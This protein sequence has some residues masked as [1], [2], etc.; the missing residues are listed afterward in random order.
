MEYVL[1]GKYVNLRFVKVEDA[2]FILSLRCDPIKSKYLNKT[3]YNIE[4]Q[5][6]Y[7]RNCLNKTDEWYFIIENKEQKPIGTYRVYDLQS[8]SFCIGS[9]LMVKGSSA[10][11][12]MEGEFLVKAF[13]F[14][15]TGFNKFHFSVRK[16]NKKVVKYHIL[17]GA[18][19]IGETD[20]DYLFSCKK[21]DYL[22]R[23]KK[24]G[25]K[26]DNVLIKM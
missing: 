23:I 25:F 8:D 20:I 24:F 17:M 2:S 1:L 9:W 22:D 14:K 19:Q 26:L 4:K 7:I 21:E 10:F 3:E 12:M 16:E 13:A 5:E 15:I 18:K 6:E 11:E